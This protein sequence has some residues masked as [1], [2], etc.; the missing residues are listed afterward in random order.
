MSKKSAKVTDDSDLMLDM[1][2]ME[3]LTSKMMSTMMPVFDKMLKSAMDTLK[4]ELKETLTATCL[5]IV[6]SRC[7]IIESRAA[8]LSSEVSDLKSQISSIETAQLRSSLVIHGLPEN[9]NHESNAVLGQNRHSDDISSFLSI[10]TSK[11]D[12]QL[13]QKDISRAYRIPTKDKNR[14]RPLILQFVSGLDRDRILWSRKMLKDP[15]TPRKD[16]IYVNKLLSKQ[17]ANL[18]AQA[19]LLVK[20]GLLYRTWTSDGLVRALL[21]ND[22]SA[23]PKRI[24]SAKDL[25]G[26]SS[27]KDLPGEGLSM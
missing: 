13:T 16:M 14:P 9:V 10:I 4:Q 1:K 7:S 26:I 19:R 11:M 22:P 17:V 23:K 18:F 21:T 24:N 3:A 15:E 12:I 25:P 5:D 8:E 20:K 27:A 2:T 6:E